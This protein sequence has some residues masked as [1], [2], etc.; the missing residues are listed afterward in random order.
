VPDEVESVMLVGHNPGIRK[1]ALSLARRAR[2]RTS[3]EQVPDRGA[4][5]ARA[6]WELAP[7]DAELVSFLKPKGCLPGKE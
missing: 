3:R 4:G 1:L 6:R 2:E 5:D 7:P